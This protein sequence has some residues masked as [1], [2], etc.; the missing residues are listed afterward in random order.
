MTIEKIESIHQDNDG[1]VYVSAVI[2]EVLLMYSQTLYDPP[3]YGPGLCEAS[4]TLSEEEY[5][6][7]N[8]YELIQFLEDLD[9]DWTLVDCSDDYYCD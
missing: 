9:L 5:L 7:D 3:E 4:F 8:E 6:P 2:D 1:V